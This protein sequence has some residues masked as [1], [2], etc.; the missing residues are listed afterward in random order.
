MRRW[1]WL[2]PFAAILVA[3]AVLMLFDL[4]FWHAVIV[5]LLL[6]CPAI[7]VW[8]VLMTRKPVN[9]GPAR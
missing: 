3:V 7:V 2:C 8:G 1:A 9:R 5:A 6:V 4:T